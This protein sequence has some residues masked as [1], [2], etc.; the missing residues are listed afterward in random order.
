MTA[1]RRLHSFDV[2]SSERTAREEVN[3][4]PQLQLE[5]LFASRRDIYSLAGAT[6]APN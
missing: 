3:V 5:P 2:T 6:L 1:G 4:A